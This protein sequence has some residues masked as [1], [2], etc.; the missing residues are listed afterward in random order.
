MCDCESLTILV[1]GRIYGDHNMLVFAY[2]RSGNIVICWQGAQK[3][4]KL[5]RDFIYRDW[6]SSD[7]KLTQ[8]FFNLAFDSV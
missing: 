1:M 4:P 5:L 8:D 6:W 2:D 7:R 3:N